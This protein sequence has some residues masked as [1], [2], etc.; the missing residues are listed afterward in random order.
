MALPRSG[1]RDQMLDE[2]LH[3]EISRISPEAPVPVMHLHWSESRLAGFECRTEC[4]ALGGQVSVL[5]S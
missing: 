3:G 1:R 2:Y 5:A 4:A